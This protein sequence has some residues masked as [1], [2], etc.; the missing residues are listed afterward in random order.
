MYT[1][2]YRYIYIY[3]DIYRYTYLCVCVS[4]CACICIHLV[5]ILYMSQEE[6]DATRAALAE[7]IYISV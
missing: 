7:F 5:A 2:I 4:T 6:L 1:D 3:K